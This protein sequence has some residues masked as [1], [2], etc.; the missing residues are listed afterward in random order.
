MLFGSTAIAGGARITRT[1]ERLRPARAAAP[2]RPLAGST[3][4]AGSCCC[5]ASDAVWKHA[6]W[7]PPATAAGFTASDADFLRPTGST[8][9]GFGVLF[10]GVMPQARRVDSAYLDQ[11]DR[12]VK[13]LAARHILR[14]A[15]L[16]PGRYATRFTAARGSRS[17]AVQDDGLPFASTGSFFTNYFTPALARDLRR[18]LGQHGGPLGLLATAWSAVAERWARQP[19]LMGYD[20]F[21]EPSAGSQ[22]ASLLQ[23]GRLP[24]FDHQL[25]SFYDHVRAGNPRPGP[26]RPRLVRPHFFFNAMAKSNFG[27]VAD[28]QVGLSWHNYAC[29][30]RVHRQRGHSG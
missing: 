27:R 19:Y 5:T 16:P 10:A 7:A 17:A 24:L 3:P 8:R 9:C 21:N 23:P 15:R 11:V 18:L 1:C 4:P 2:R 22:L 20:L 26:R 25:Q 6:P 28:P 29:M 12:V 13:L 14:P 30:P